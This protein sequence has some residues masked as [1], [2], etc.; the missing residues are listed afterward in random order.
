MIVTVC[1]TFQFA[2]VK[3][4]LDGETEPSDA[5]LESTEITTSAVGGA[6]RTKENVA[7]PLVS[8]VA[9]PVVG[10]TV[11]PGVGFRMARPRL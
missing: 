9:S 3:V 7:L 8:V 5:S 11:K 1:G 4:K 6:L 10:V 2:G